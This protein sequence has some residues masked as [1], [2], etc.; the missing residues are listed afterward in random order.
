VEVSQGS[1]E[2]ELMEALDQLEANS[3]FLLEIK[4][5]AEKCLK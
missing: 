1:G 5:L 3:K 4:Q 2:L